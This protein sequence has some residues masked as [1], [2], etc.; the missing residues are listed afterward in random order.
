MNVIA[1]RDGSDALGLAAATPEQ[2]LHNFQVQVTQPSTPI[3]NIVFA[4]MGGSALQA[5]FITSYPVLTVPFVI[6]KDYDL[7]AFVD[8]STL[9][10]VS[11]YSGNTEETLSALEQAAEKNAKIVVMTGGGKLLEIAETKGYDHVIIP[12]AVQPRMAVLYAYRALVELLVA[13]DVASSESISALE[14]VE[15][16]LHAAIAGWVQTVS[17]AENPAKQLALQLV[18][19]TPII[20]AGTH[21]APAAYKWK[22]SVNENAKNTAWMGRLP[23]FNHNEFMGWSS[24]PVEKPFAV[25]DLLSSFEHP[26]TQL[27]F[28]VGDRLLSG[29]RPKAITVTAQG[30]S[31]LEH[32]LYLML[33]GDFVTLYL[34]L[35]NGVDPSP[36]VLVEKFKHELG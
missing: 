11:S 1:Q 2:L 17:T 8:E 32:L 29:L 3:S 28:E 25:V 18:G 26:R 5:E 24:H 4:A 13:Y 35:L 27:R 14:A 31:V 30:D 23:E 7:P 34:G 15:P 19:K 16:R 33:F 6:V 9:V 21:M 12:K 20:Y 22:I 36:V 10:I